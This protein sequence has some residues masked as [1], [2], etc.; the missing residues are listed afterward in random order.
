MKQRFLTIGLLCVLA[1]S[2]ST[3]CLVSTVR[4]SGNVISETRSVA[5]F[6]NVSLSG[7]G[8]LYIIEG[9]EE[10]LEIEAEDNLLEHIETEVR[11]RTLEIKIE[12]PLE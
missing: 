10:S 9:D 2:F 3:A 5:N 6:E 7:I 12:E 8:T 11:G 1:F 4:G